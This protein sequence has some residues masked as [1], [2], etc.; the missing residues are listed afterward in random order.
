MSEY[1]RALA[2][3]IVAG[4]VLGLVT[5]FVILTWYWF[6]TGTA[7]GWYVR[8]IEATYE[9]RFSA[10]ALAGSGGLG[11]FAGAR[12][13]RRQ[14]RRARKPAGG[15]EPHEALVSDVREVLKGEG[16]YSTHTHRPTSGG[17]PGGSGDR[18]VP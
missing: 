5:G 16:T 6:F 1:A 10:L 18:S 8:W 14:E 17:E 13:T 12:V 4:V 11:W 3:L 7:P 15:R 2:K 9:P